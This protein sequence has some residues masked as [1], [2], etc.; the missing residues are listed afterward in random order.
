MAASTAA[1][2][3]SVGS[4]AYNKINSICRYHKIEGDTCYPSLGS[5]GDGY[6][7]GPCCN[8]VTG[9]NEECM[10]LEGWTKPGW[11]TCKKRAGLFGGFACQ[12]YGK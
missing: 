3:Y 2:V 9:D 6:V 12:E 8:S 10:K 1:T 11:C 7:P 5:G 4:E